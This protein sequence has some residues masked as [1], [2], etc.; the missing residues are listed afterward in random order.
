MALER[1]AQLHKTHQVKTNKIT[2]LLGLMLNAM[3]TLYTLHIWD[4]SAT[5][6]NSLHKWFTKIFRYR[7]WNWFT[8]DHIMITCSRQTSTA[9]VARTWRRHVTTSYQ[10]GGCRSSINWAVTFSSINILMKCTGKQ[11]TAQDTVH[12][13]I[14]NNSKYTFRQSEIHDVWMWSEINVILF[15]IFIASIHSECCS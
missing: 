13:K 2:D 15:Q 12:Y 6:Q 10:A 8:S 5:K 7:M 14:I 4:L 11:Y 1:G 3:Y 9:Y